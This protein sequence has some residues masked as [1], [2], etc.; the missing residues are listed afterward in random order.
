LGFQLLLKWIDKLGWDYFVATSNVDGH[1]EKAGF[2]SECVYEI[3]GSINHIQCVKPCCKTIWQL[4]QVI[5]IDESTMRSVNV[6]VCPRCGGTARPSI[7]LYGDRHFIDTRLAGQSSKFSDFLQRIRTRALLI[8]EIGAGTGMP[9]VRNVTESLYLHK[10]VKVIRINTLEPEI[11]PP[12]IAL[13]CRGLEAL[14]R[15]DKKWFQK[16]VQ[17]QR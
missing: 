4:D 5:E 11:D 10:N 13:Q 1:F 8:I 9:V 15:I 16:E 12:H 14:Q 2:P 3:H 7:P 6:P 17:G